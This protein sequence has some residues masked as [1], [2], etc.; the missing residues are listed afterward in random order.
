MMSR[1]M[2]T[3]CKISCVVMNELRKVVRVSLG[4]VHGNFLSKGYQSIQYISILET[5]GN[6]WVKVVL[7]HFNHQPTY[8]W[9]L[10]VK[11]LYEA[12]LDVNF[13]F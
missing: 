13:L 5:D 12:V 8:L 3:R 9:Y 4:R 7:I 6:S 1:D 10:D 2:G 11:I